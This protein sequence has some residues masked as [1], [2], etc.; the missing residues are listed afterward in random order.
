MPSINECVT[1]MPGAKPCSGDRDLSYY[2]RLM[3]EG[4]IAQVT[5]IDREAF[6]PQWPPV[7]FEHELHSW[8]AHYIVACEDSEMEEKPGVRQLFNYARFYSVELPPLAREYIAGF[9]G[10]WMTADEAHITNIAVRKIHRRQGIGERLLISMIDLATE[11]NARILT[12]EVRASNIAAQNLYHKYG[13]AQ[14]GLRRGYYTDNKEDAVLMTIENTTSASFQ[15]RLNQ[16]KKAHS[17]RWG[18]APCQVAR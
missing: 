17:Q 6:P 14:V 4:D 10:F 2:V 11:L 8:L 12:L 9:G 5:E 16:L 7:D 18:I 13:F 3:R 1:I 15:S